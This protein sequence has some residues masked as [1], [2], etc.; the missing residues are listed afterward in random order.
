MIKLFSSFPLATEVSE[1]QGIDD[2][3]HAAAG[4]IRL[5]FLA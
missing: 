5:G 1:L 2:C 4:A 3:E